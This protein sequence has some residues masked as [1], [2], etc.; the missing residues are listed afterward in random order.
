MEANWFFLNGS[1]Q[2]AKTSNNICPQLVSLLYISSNCFNGSDEPILK[3]TQSMF[4][5]RFR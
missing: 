3:Y 2:D 1:W 4:N 5:E